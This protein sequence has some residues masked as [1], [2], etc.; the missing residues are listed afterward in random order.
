MAY[1]KK[2]RDSRERGVCVGLRGE[3]C[4][5]GVYLAN[6]CQKHYRKW[7]RYGRPENVPT[8]DVAFNETFRTFLNWVDLEGDD[9]QAAAALKETKA[10]FRTYAQVLNLGPMPRGM[11]ADT[12]C[13]WSKKLSVKELQDLVR[14]M[15]S[16]L[17]FL[18]RR[19]LSRVFG[20]LTVE[21][22]RARALEGAKKRVAKWGNGYMK[23]LAASG[24][25]TR[26]T[27]EKH[28]PP[29]GDTRSAAA[30]AARVARLTSESDPYSGDI[31][32]PAPSPESGVP[33]AERAM[34]ETGEF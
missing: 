12:V 26:W 33:S 2:H 31:D 1:A 5:R 11:D 15:C 18:Q 25:A 28:P 16:R 27:K 30:T 19:V 22:R 13:E 20:R 32:A 34:L 3:G 23:Q 24:A 21:E 6:R 8:E 7:L 9:V 4:T 14:R 10:A 17:T 29:P